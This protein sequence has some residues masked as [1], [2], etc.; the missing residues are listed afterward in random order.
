MTALREMASFARLVD[1]LEPFLD[2]LVFV[3]GWAHRLHALHALA[4]PP[5]FEPLATED[6]RSGS[7][8][9]LGSQSDRAR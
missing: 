4:R 9:A 6:R 1:A 8:S 7:A 2:V 3:G 5:D